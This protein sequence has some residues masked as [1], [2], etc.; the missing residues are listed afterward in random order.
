MSVSGITK[1]EIEGKRCSDCKNVQPWKAFSRR[2][3]PRTKAKKPEYY[4]VCKSC[5]RLRSHKWMYQNPKRYLAYEA[6]RATYRGRK[7]PLCA[8]CKGEGTLCWYRFN[9]QKALYHN[10]CALRK[11]EDLG[12]IPEE[13]KKHLQRIASQGFDGTL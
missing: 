11:Y 12:L 1:I 3:T 4:S 9:K 5:M 2:K 8:Y 13:R 7:T 10:S 6:L